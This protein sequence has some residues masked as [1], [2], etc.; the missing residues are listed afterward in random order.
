MKKTVVL[1]LA[2]LT[3]FLY[4]LQAQ[5]RKEYATIS[6][7]EMY[8][9]TFVEESN[10]SNTLFND[11]N[12]TLALLKSHDEAIT[13]N[14][15]TQYDRHFTPLPK[16]ETFQDTNT[17][18]WLKVNLGE[19]FPSGRFVYSYGDADFS[20]HTIDAEQLLEKFKL[21][22]VQHIKFNYTAGKDSQIYYFKLVPKHY[23]IPF[24]F[25]NVS[26]SDTFYT[27]MTYEFKTQLLAGIILGLILM[28][29]IFNGAM[30]YYYMLMQL[31]MLALL[32][33]YT[34]IYFFES[35]SFFSRNIIYE[36]LVSLG[37]ALFA[38]LFNIYF[39][40]TKRTMP[41]LNIYFRTTVILI[42]LDMVATLIDKSYI[43]AFY[44]YPFL[45]LPFLYAGFTRLKQGY[46]PSRFYL[47]GWTALTLAVFV[48]VFSVG[49]DLFLIDPLYIGAATE[50]ILLSLAISYKMRMI[51]QQKE[52][53]KELLVHQSKLASM[54]EMIGN[55]AHQWR[56]PL[57]HLGY[58]FMN[59]QEKEKHGELNSQYLKRKI[60]EAN[61][62]LTF[63]SDTIEDFQ[64]F[65]R[66]DKEKELFSLA[67]AT[68]ETLNMMKNTFEHH[69]IEV[70]LTVQENTMLYNYKNEYKQVLVNLLSNAKDALIDRAVPSATITIAVKS[71]SVSIQDN[72]KGVDPKIFSQICEPYF[73]TKK[74][75]TGIGLYMSKIIIEKN[76]Q[77]ALRLDNGTHGLTCILTF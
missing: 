16:E 72:A 28:A 42:I 77:G 56:Q 8:G 26:T 46:K 52:E 38:T 50:A 54:G 45:M 9:E 60:D 41:K 70:T 30:F 63:M 51:S 31:C 21:N 73:S 23:R 4:T 5:E 53:Q 34:G 37:A 69:G 36:S 75:S 14:T 24:R 25:L 17:T 67:D 65:Y 19:H 39:L 11:I 66:P 61:V 18:Y 10:R 44:L 58:I 55:I 74:N 43:D 76:M 2:L 3:L 64:S 6:I 57:T 68:N 35:N 22:G 15:I 13:I 27:Y 47:A 1:T 71:H 32:V 12:I 40:D 49:Y 33:E 20:E 29:A 59:I 7:Y 48:N 62:Q